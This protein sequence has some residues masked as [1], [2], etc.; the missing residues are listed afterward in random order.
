MMKQFWIGYWF[1]PWYFLYRIGY[2]IVISGIRGF[3]KTPI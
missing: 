2:A 3:L 1:K